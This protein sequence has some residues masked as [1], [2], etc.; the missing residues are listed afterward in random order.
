MS[1]IIL[2]LR[3]ALFNIVSI[4]ANI[5]LC[6][7]LVWALFIPYHLAH[8]AILI[9]FK[10]MHILEKYIIGLDYKVEGRE[11]LPK[12]GSYIIAMKHQSLYE[13]FKVFMIFGF[14]AIIMKK[15]LGHIPFWGWYARKT[16]MIFVD[17]GA[18]GKA[19][20]SLIEN[21]KHVVE[22]QRPILIYPQGTRTRIDETVQDKPYK[23]GI[24]R[25]YKNY[26]LP[27]VPVAMN[28]GLFWPKGSFIKKPG[29]VTF[30]ILTPIESG[31]DDKEV[32]SRLQKTLESESQKLLEK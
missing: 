22:A 13:T 31:L 15:E 1:F 9:Y 24:V 10:S 23:Q 8:K 14:I 7:G 18:R 28:S 25:L 2:F 29:T 20:K 17:R 3:S 30:K 19:V 27:I 11:N 26:D 4:I 16:K 32:M 5:I 12:Q 21:A 6:V